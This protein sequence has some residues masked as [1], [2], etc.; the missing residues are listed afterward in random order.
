MQGT[1]S[2]INISMKTLKQILMLPVIPSAATFAGVG[3]N[4]AISTI[5]GGSIS[6][7]WTMIN[8]I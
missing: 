8:T 7:M 4:L 2:A 3:I 6:A 1:L 5:F